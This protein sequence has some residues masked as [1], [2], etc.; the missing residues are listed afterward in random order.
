METVTYY[1]NITKKNDDYFIFFDD[2]VSVDADGILIIP[3]LIGWEEITGM[4]SVGRII[5]P[6]IPFNSGQ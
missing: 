3:T 4:L 5:T 6:L 1:N 2:I